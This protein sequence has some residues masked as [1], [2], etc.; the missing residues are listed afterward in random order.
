M[1]KEWNIKDKLKE[2]LKDLGGLI[3]LGGNTT[4]ESEFEYY[5]DEALS[6]NKDGVVTDA[7]G[8]E[9]TTSGWEKLWE[10]LDIQTEIVEPVKSE[11]EIDEILA[12]IYRYGDKD[13]K[14]PTEFK[15]WLDTFCI[16]STANVRA[17]RNYFNSYFYT[18]TIMRQFAEH[19]TV[20]YNDLSM[21]MCNNSKM[22]DDTIQVIDKQLPLINEKWDVFKMLRDQFMIVVAN[23]TGM[24][25]KSRVKTM[26][27]HFE[28]YI[29]KMSSVFPTENGGQIAF[30]ELI[31]VYFKP[32]L[33]YFEG[34]GHKPQDNC[35]FDAKEAAHHASKEVIK[36]LQ[37]GL[38]KGLDNLV[39]RAR[40]RVPKLAHKTKAK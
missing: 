32:A 15:S 12:D 18:K 25:P 26:L 19:M 24:N 31:A 3:G 29:Y 6:T 9:V 10:G 22:S 1:L 20:G 21:A 30:D 28:H 34:K 23:A 37:L 5:D 33:K 40:S 39:T 17:L 2:G 35:P 11:E 8:N 13:R 38:I 36:S 27:C 4:T 14:Y 16:N 7:D